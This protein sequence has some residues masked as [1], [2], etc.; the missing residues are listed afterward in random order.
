MT[1]ECSSTHFRLRGGRRFRRVHMLRPDAERRADAPECGAAAETC[2]ISLNSSGG[3][4]RCS[5][6]QRRL[7]IRFCIVSCMRCVMRAGN[8]RRSWIA[9]R[10]SSVTVPALQRRGQAVGGGHRVLHGEIDA[11]AADRRHRMRGVADADQPRPPPL[12]Q[13]IDRHGQKLHVVQAFDLADA[14]GEERRQFDHALAECLDA[15]RLDA[16]RCRPSE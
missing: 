8:V 11:D 4:G 9:C 14:V 10:S 15:G 13:P 12:P 6:L 7:M 1:I 16:S 5:A 3:F 2:P